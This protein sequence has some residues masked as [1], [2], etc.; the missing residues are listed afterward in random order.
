MEN[1]K[2]KPKVALIGLIMAL[3][4][5]AEREKDFTF[6][7]PYKGLMDNTL[8]SHNLMPTIGTRKPQLSKKQRKARNK[9]KN[10]KKTRKKNCR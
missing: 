4:L 1:I 6:T 8:I 7:N 3:D 10:A 5:L 9:A 2:E